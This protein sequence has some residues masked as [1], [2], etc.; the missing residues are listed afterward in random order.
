[1]EG[2]RKDYA[3]TLKD[4]EDVDVSAE[5]LSSAGVWELFLPDLTAGGPEFA[6]EKPADR[7]IPPRTSFR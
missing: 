7:G 5:P 6:V 2:A 1:M 3:T 4:A